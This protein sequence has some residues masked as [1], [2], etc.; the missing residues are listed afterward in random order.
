MPQQR[1]VRQTT[2]EAIRKEVVLSPAAA[3]P[4]QLAKHRGGWKRIWL[5]EHSVPRLMWQTAALREGQCVSGRKRAGMDG[6]GA[7]EVNRGQI[8]KEPVRKLAYYSKEL[9]SY[10][11]LSTVRFVLF[12][13]F[14]FNIYIY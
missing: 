14:I 12:L 11:K 6:G 7:G 13:F 5:R 4:M 8:L 3:D 9:W 10:G 2:Q 1:E